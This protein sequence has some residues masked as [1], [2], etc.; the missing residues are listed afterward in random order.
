MLV[1]YNLHKGEIIFNDNVVDDSGRAKIVGKLT[2]FRDLDRLSI[3]Q[4]YKYTTQKL[5]DVLKM[6]GSLFRDRSECMELVNSLRNF[7]VEIGHVISESNDTKGNKLSS[8]AQNVSAK[9]KLSFILKCNIFSGVEDKKEFKVEI[10]CDVRDKALELWLES[11]ELK[12]IID[13][14]KEKTII[15]EL[16]HFKSKVPIIQIG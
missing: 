4:D 11:V 7:S 10:L 15:S 5:S 2:E 12:E 8:F 13:S 3:N 1:T 9:F 6:S 14:E 16:V